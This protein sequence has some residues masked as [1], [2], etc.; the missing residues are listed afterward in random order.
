MADEV[1]P[2]APIPEPALAVVPEPIPEPIQPQ[3]EAPIP[4]EP[5]TAQ[6]PP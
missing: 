5:P 1:V 4:P 6:I 3:V 2:D